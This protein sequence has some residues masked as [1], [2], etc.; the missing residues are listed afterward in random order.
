[1]GVGMGSG[2]GSG[3]AT[4]TVSVQSVKRALLDAE[5]QARLLDPE[6]EAEAERDRGEVVR[7][8]RERLAFD[9]SPRRP[10]AGPPSAIDSR[11]GGLPATLES[12]SS[13]ASS[14]VR[15]SSCFAFSC[16]LLLALNLHA[17]ALFLA[18]RL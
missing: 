1:M 2:S 13:A 7:V 4:P 5:T 3:S 9:D 15:H 12:A 16:C 10:P 17:A 14:P 6:A 8:K 11:A 18:P